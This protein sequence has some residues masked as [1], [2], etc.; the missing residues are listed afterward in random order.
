MVADETPLELASSLAGLFQRGLQ[1]VIAADCWSSTW[2]MTAAVPGGRSLEAESQS[3]HK[4]TV[5]ECSGILAL[6]HRR[7]KSPARPGKM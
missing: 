4:R 3:G 1:L 6:A 2:V 7:T 5:E